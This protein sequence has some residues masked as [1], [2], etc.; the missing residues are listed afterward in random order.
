MFRFAVDRDCAKNWQN[1]CSRRDFGVKAEHQSYVDDFVELNDRTRADLV[2]NASKLSRFR[3]FKQRM[4][5]NNKDKK[6]SRIEF[7][8]NFD[9]SLWSQEDIARFKRTNT[10]VKLGVSRGTR[11][12][13]Q[14]RRNLEVAATTLEDK[15]KTQVTCLFIYICFIIPLF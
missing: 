4:K 10:R 13:S 7:S 6:I 9:S 5:A 14:F 2:L 8:Y 12:D 11:K 15:L 3:A 1:P